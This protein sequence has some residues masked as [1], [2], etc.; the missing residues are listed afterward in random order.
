[1]CDP[2]EGHNCEWRGEWLLDNEDTC[3]Q[4]A[5]AIAN[6]PCPAFIWALDAA[7]RAEHHVMEV[8]AAFVVTVN[9]RL[10]NVSWT[11]AG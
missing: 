5:G 10:L 6:R 3:Q 7:M 1:M 4:V 8:G 9:G 11:S 2:A